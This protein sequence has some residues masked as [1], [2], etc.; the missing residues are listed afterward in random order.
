MNVRLHF[1]FR[2]RTWKSRSAPAIRGCLL[3]HPQNGGRP[4]HG[5]VDGE[6]YMKCPRCRSFILSSAGPRGCHRWCRINATESGYSLLRPDMR[7]DGRTRRRSSVERDRTMRQF[8]TATGFAV[9]AA[10]FSGCRKEAPVERRL[11]DCTN[12]TLRFQMTVQEFPAYY[13]VLGMP[14][15][16]NRAVELP[17]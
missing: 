11:A 16:C 1:G 2:A 13:F 12:S 4:E 8:I 9:V 10:L 3:Q 15:T 6:G 14:Q 5:T 17:R 7:I